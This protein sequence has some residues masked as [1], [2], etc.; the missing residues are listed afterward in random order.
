[1][2]DGYRVYSFGNNGYG[3]LGRPTMQNGRLS[4]AYLPKDKPITCVACG[5]FFSII[6]FGLLC[7]LFRKDGDNHYFL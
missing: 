1:M 6:V 7:F 2:I 3:Q 4:Q 5:D